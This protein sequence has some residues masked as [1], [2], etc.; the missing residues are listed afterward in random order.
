MVDPFLPGTLAETCPTL[1]TPSK[2]RVVLPVRQMAMRAMCVVA[3]GTTLKATKQEARLTARLK[4]GDTA[5][6]LLSPLRGR[7]EDRARVA[8]ADA[9]VVPAASAGHLRPFGHAMAVPVAVPLRQTSTAVVG[10]L[11]VDAPP[12]AVAPALDRDIGGLVGA[13]SH[14]GR[15]GTQAT[16]GVGLV[17]RDTGPPS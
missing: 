3:T 17:G 14:V 1:A 7:V 4:D 6:S 2:V 15:H 13:S 8:V 10:G 5:V 11:G 9:V 16:T 12:S